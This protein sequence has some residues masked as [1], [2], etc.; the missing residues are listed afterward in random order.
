MAGEVA[1]SSS[2]SLVGRRPNCSAGDV[3]AVGP[4]KLAEVLHFDTEAPLRAENTLL[5]FSDADRNW[6]HCLHL[7]RHR[8]RPDRQDTAFAQHG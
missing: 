4:N 2:L 1:E 5:S 7:G 3:L 6:K 8:D